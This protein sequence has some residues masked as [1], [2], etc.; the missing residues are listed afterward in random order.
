MEAHRLA[1]LATRLEA[2]PP[3]LRNPILLFSIVKYRAGILVPGPVSKTL[4]GQAKVGRF[5][6][7]FDK[8]ILGKYTNVI[9][10]GRTKK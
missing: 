4:F 9:Y 6:K 7:S 2:V 1:Q 3:A 5:I 8:A 10:N